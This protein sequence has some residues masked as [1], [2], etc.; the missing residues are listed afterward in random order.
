MTAVI[1]RFPGDAFEEILASVLGSL[2]LDDSEAA[3]TLKWK[4]AAELSDLGTTARFAESFIEHL[5]D[6]MRNLL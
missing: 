2:L 3:Q 6:L 1:A 5:G 4:A